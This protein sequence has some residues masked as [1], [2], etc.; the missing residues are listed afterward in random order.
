M[1]HLRVIP[2]YC[3][4]FLMYGVVIALKKMMMMM[5]MTRVGKVDILYAVVT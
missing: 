4:A 3:T 2:L 5:M 1:L